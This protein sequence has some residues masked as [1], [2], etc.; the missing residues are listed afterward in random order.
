MTKLDDN[1]LKSW[2]NGSIKN[3][4]VDFLR[5]TVEDGSDYIKPEDRIATFDND[6]TLWVE[7][8]IPVQ[9]DF[10]FHSFKKSAQ[11]D[12]S[13]ACQQPYKAILENDSAFISDI[14]KQS[15]DAIM[16]L[17]KAMARAWNGKTPKEFELEVKEFIKT[18][19]H[20][21]FS[22]FYTDLVY[23]PMLELFD[24]LKHYN[25]R[26]FVCSGGGRDFM[27]VIA[28]DTWDIHKENVIGTAP[29]YEYKNGELR[30]ITKVLGGIS[31]GPGKVEHIFARTGRL[32]VFAAGNSNCDMDM[33]NCAKY[34][35]VVNHDDHEREYSYDKGAGKLINNAKKYDF[36]ILSMKKDWKVIF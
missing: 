31:L 35:L 25:Y 8:P 4:I 33:L 5:S 23:K 20:L 10:M 30:R 24:L 7:R 14:L 6:G 22:V 19:K 13:L 36:N 11:Q 2:N 15:P 21:K 26:I 27:R 29:E 17:E 1:K 18:A 32:P 9:A 34:K 28:E 16:S 12:P 3:S